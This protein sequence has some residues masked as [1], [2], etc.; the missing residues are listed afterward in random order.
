MI[1]T[2]VWLPRDMHEQLKKAGGE[3]GLGEEIRRRLEHA[4]EHA[5]AALEAPR[6][7]IT[8]ELLAQIRDITRDV[9]CDEPWHTN[10]FTFDVIKAAV[11]ALVSSHQPSSDAKPETIAHLEAVYG[12]K[13]PEIIGRIIAR[14][15]IFAYDR[16]R[17]GGAFL[18]A[19]KG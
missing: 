5:L 16:E 1:Q 18:K 19:L 9:S 15:A 13:N 14:A 8:D 4:Q 7:D 10:R 12:D 11:N 6:D 2:A 17:W 3:R